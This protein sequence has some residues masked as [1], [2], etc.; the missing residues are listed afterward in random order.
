MITAG[1]LLELAAHHR[2]SV[3]SK[4]TRDHTGTAVCYAINGNW[5]CR[6]LPTNPGYN[7]QHVTDLL[8]HE[9]AVAEGWA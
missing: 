6:P 7:G 1:R 3:H 9:V 4:I 8:A 2:A 5:Y